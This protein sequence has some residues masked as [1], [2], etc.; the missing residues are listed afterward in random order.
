MKQKVLYGWMTFGAIVGLV[1]SFWQLLEKLT[2]L[3]NSQAVLSCNLN[4]VFNCS[5]V[6]NAHQSSV[7]GFPNSLMC[8]IFF[9]M[10]LTAGLIGWGGAA[11]HKYLR[12]FFQAFALFFIGFGFWYLWQ[13]I[14]NLAAL[15]IFCLF[16]YGGLLVVSAAWFRLNYQDYPNGKKLFGSL[17]A[18]GGDLFIWCLIGAAIALEAIL[19]FA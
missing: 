12:F 1:A 6:L 5:N 17:V 4:S 10:M 16:C 7:F 9:V 11:I 2:L 19:K 15:C 14:Y 3:K 8:V 13:S 18:R